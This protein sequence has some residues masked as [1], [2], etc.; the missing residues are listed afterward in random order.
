VSAGHGKRRANQGVH[1]PQE[2]EREDILHVVTVSSETHKREYYIS[3]FRCI[4][5]FYINW[6][7]KV[8]FIIMDVWILHE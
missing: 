8:I 2:Q 4:Y 3:C 6:L 7:D 1:S 5:F